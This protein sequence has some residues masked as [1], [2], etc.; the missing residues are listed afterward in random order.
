MINLTNADGHKLKIEILDYEFPNREDTGGIPTPE[1]LEELEDGRD[2]DAN[3]LM[4]RFTGFNGE[5]AWEAT[6]P[7]LLT[8]EVE[9]ILDWFVRMAEGIEPENISPTMFFLEPCFTLYQHHND[10]D[11]YR[12][13]FALSFELAPP[14]EQRGAEYYMDFTLTRDEIAQMTNGIAEA[15]SRFPAR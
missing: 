12:I 3:W 13:R 1:Q 5:Q 8:W 10:D 15:L 9:S 6:D 4:L 14:D 11:T 7:C 2:Y